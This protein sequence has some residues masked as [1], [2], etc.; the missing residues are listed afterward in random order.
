MPGELLGSSA[1]SPAAFESSP[2]RPSRSRCGNTVSPVCA[3]VGDVNLPRRVREECGGLVAGGRDAGVLD[4]DARE[5]IDA[6]FRPTRYAS[7]PPDEKPATTTFRDGPRSTSRCRRSRRGSLR[8]VARPC[9]SS[10]RPGLPN[11]DADVLLRRARVPR[12]H[13]PRRKVLRVVPAAVEP[14]DEAHRRD[15]V[16]A[17]GDVHDVRALGTVRVKKPASLSRRCTSAVGFGPAPAFGST[18]PPLVLPPL[19]RCAPLVLG[20]VRTAARA[21]VPTA[22]ALH[23]SAAAAAPRPFESVGTASVPCAGS[24]SPRASPLAVAPVRSC[25]GTAS[26]AVGCARTAPSDEMR[27]RCKRA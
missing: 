25:E 21:V 24:R 12:V 9:S 6:C 16:V 17:R 14:D 19:R 7:S 18:G 27:Q 5:A 8:V 2:S 10:C 26:L 23:R 3:R 20:P 1:G 13:A 4:E 15:A 11:R 22:A